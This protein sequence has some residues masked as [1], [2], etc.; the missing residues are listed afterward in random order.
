MMLDFPGYSE[1][2][3]INDG[4]NSYILRA[5]KGK[6]EVV[7]KYLNKKRPS[8]EDLL[9]FQYEYEILKDI[10]DDYIINV[11]DFQALD[12]SCFMVMQDTHSK[13]VEE[14]LNSA[15][16]SF[17]E[18]LHIALQAAKALQSLQKRHIIH[19]AVTL[20]NLLYNVEDKSLKLINFSS[21][22]TLLFE[23]NVFKSPHAQEGDLYYF[24]PEQT[25][26]M[27]RTIDYRS[28]LYSLGVSL[29]KLFCGRFPFEQSNKL[30]LYHAIIATKA[31]SPSEIDSSVP[32]GISNIIMK[33][34]EKNAEQRYQ[35]AH[36]LAS[37]IST[38]I[39]LL[40]TNENPD[41][42]LGKDD[43]AGKLN[44]PQK[45]F[46][47][48]NEVK[49]LMKAFDRVAK[50][51]KEMLLVAG[52]SGVGKSVLVNEVHKPITK[53]KGF[54]IEGKFDQFQR[55]KPYLT[56]IQAFSSWIEMILSEP[57]AEQ[58]IWRNKILQALG[59]NAQVI[60][61]LI[62]SFEKL[63]GKQDEAQELSGMEAQNRFNFLFS[64]LIRSIASKDH[65]LVI[66]V[67]DLQWSDQATLNLIEALLHDNESSHFLLFG[68][69]RD[70]EVDD[71]HPFI[72]S[73]TQ[74][75][76]EKVP[77]SV[78]EI[79]NLKK[80]DVSELL[81]QTL[82]QKKAKISSLVDLIYDKTA[83]N[84]FFVN[85]FI[86]SLEH[87]KLISFNY[88]SQKWEWDIQAL[89]EKNL[90]DNVVDLMSKQISKFSEKTQKSLT[91][92]ACIG[93]RFDLHTL[94]II[95]EKTEQESAL[96]LEDVLKHG[97]IIPLK[98]EYKYTS[99]SQESDNI[100]YKFAHDRIQQAAYAFLSPEQKPYIHLHIGALL[101]ESITDEQL[102]EN[103]FDIV[104]HKNIGEA[105]ITDSKDRLK[106]AE[107]NYMAA[108]KAKKSVAFSAAYEFLE[109]FHKYV[110]AN[111]WKSNYQLSYNA[112]ILKAEIA[113]MIQDFDSSKKLVNEILKY[114]KTGV[115]KAKAQNISIVRET[116]QGRYKEALEYGREGMALT[117]F[118]LPD[119]EYEENFGKDLQE[120][121][122]YLQ[123]H[124]IASLSELSLCENEAVDVATEILMNLVPP[125][126][127]VFKP[128]YPIV[129]SSLVLL[130]IKNG[131]TQFSSMGYSNYGI[132]LSAAL[133]QHQ[134]G[135]D[136]G[137]VSLEVG[138]DFKHMQQICKNSF[139]FATFLNNWVRPIQESE[140]VNDEG[141]HMGMQSG[142]LQFVGYILHS[143]LLNA[144]IRGDSLDDI[145]KNLPQ[146]YHFQQKTQ[147]QWAI[148][149]IGAL[150]LAI[151]KLKGEKSYLIEEQ[152]FI[153]SVSENESQHGLCF[154]KIHMAQVEFI[155]KN[156]NT[157]YSLTQEAEE[158]LPN[159]YGYL[160]TAECNF[161]NS[162]SLSMLALQKDPKDRED[163]IKKIQD[164]QKLLQIW[165]DNVKENFEHKL[166]FIQAQLS[167]LN[168]NIEEA[169]V[170]YNK[171]L[172]S[173][174]HNNFFQ[175]MGILSE[176]F[177]LFLYEHDIKR[178]SKIYFQDALYYYDR[179]S[180]DAKVKE[181]KSFIQES[182]KLEESLSSEGVQELDYNS[183]IKSIHLLSS[184]IQIS[185]LISN[186][187]S[188]SM[189]NAGAQ[190]AVLLFSNKNELEVIIEK[191]A[192]S[193][194]NLI[195]KQLSTFNQDEL[196]IHSLV[197]KAYTSLQAIIIDNALEDETYSENPYVKKNK[198]LSILVLPVIQKNTLE[199]ILYLEN[200]LVSNLFTPERVE[201][202]SIL[203]AQAAISFEN[204]RL[205]SNLENK[206]QERTEALQSSN[207]DLSTAIQNLQQ[208]QDQLVESEKIAALGNLVAGVAHEINTPVGLSI[209]GI[210]HF[211]NEAKLMNE[212]YKGNK[213][214]Q[215]SFEEF[216][217][218]TESLAE[219][220]NK[221]LTHAAKL[222]KSFKEVAVGQTNERINDFL[223]KEAIDQVI[224][225]FGS[226]LKRKHIS[227]DVQCDSELKLHSYTG[228]IYQ[229][230]TNL[231]NNAIIH[232]FDENSSGHISIIVKEKDDSVMVEFCDNGK[233]ISEKNI[234]KIFD[235]FFTTK[236]GQGGTG[237]GL[238]IIYNIITQ[239]LQGKISASSTQKPK[240]TCFIISFPK[241]L[242]SET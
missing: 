182:F 229:V 11:L 100:L 189:E 194:P 33:L 74:M 177:G 215:S 81:E 227:V 138:K 132:V 95:S 117:G 56:M 97:L 233:G 205:Y 213:M 145:Q 131:N 55:D 210:T 15:L 24:S 8:K 228:S 80:E 52:Y 104:N 192:Q 157:A 4:H 65:P 61:D 196:L 185:T 162:L 166:L 148:D 49:E 168:N 218:T 9:H 141:Y 84:A 204:S 42:K 219:L 200:S 10:Q 164:N 149:S 103:L 154:Y 12:N 155:F 91:L 217:D 235:P 59:R 171:A 130:S 82:L 27:N 176:V 116:M 184:E 35:S 105:L 7:I 34:L 179:W 108:V 51:S 23:Q 180:A 79:D 127:I 31:S 224:I 190:R 223:L 70:N 202:L 39:E 216:L 118:P 238:H 206:V 173:A 1:V 231:V 86:H 161:Y 143:K 32:Q 109:F 75:Q 137:R 5:L 239:R 66:F 90:T 92:A 156:Y 83:G 191:E 60:I 167:W 122:T 13:S 77:I 88:E 21:C 40:E 198:P 225:S 158:L 62:P 102:D 37:D 107:L 36:G 203:G 3:K 170:F 63:L 14:L 128:L 129:C 222:I 212:R 112:Y 242:P 220:I 153:E 101:Y 165:S 106:L 126:Y 147:N 73:I 140:D 18:K 115:E 221:N 151:S 146:S 125:S 232:A 78:L 76:K 169:R 16:L 186:Y 187:V 113:Y 99:F 236:M 237:L 193:E 195:E 183:V 71:A 17:K 139:I 201:L 209:T 54:F 68:A 211:Q 44:I 241:S 58:E 111:H 87:E 25:G 135:Y 119:S 234:S 142:E 150:A 172:E 26:R 96:D 41:F 2:K 226:P 230:F 136:F 123:D 64:S 38:Y 110:D 181:I 240:L 133:G 67:D 98:E 47:R 160:A 46:G 20:S 120:I 43:L 214:T 89:H 159:I 152:T 144:F 94:S 114:A 48:E 178:I 93:N 45:L 22:I 19:K 28:D 6:Q 208:T 57:K 29:Y 124:S 121:N 69:Y 85:N 50:G 163:D 199:A 175:D 72:K 207:K 197:A 30:E 188:I 53:E 134:A 174:L